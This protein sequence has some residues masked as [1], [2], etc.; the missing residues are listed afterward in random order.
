MAVRESQDRR[1]D[2]DSEKLLTLEEAAQRLGC[3]ANDVEAMVR[4]GTLPSFRLGGSLIRVRLRDVE[5]FSQRAL[6][7]QPL[8]SA[9]DT[10]SAVRQVLL[11]W[12]R[13]VDFLHFNDFYLVAFL[14][15]LTLLAI[16]FAL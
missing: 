8:P 1:L 10:R 11:F 6:N 14:V 7:R 4:E 2:S 5:A 13:V 15:I 3:P 12:T 16:I 9:P